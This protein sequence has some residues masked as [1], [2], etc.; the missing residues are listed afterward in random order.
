M[1]TAV[2]LRTNAEAA[3]ILNIKPNTLE[4]WRLKG[5]GPRF[6]KMGK[7]KQA[8]IRYDEAEVLAWLEAQTCT[9]TSQYT[10]RNQAAQLETV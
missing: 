7:E 2:N 9:S 10:A 1:K 6:I 8:P 3:A 5:K 4:I